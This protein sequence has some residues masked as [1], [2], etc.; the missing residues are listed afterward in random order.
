MEE[1]ESDKDDEDDDY[2]EKE[3][4][5]EDITTIHEEKKMKSYKKV[6]NLKI[7]FKVEIPLSNAIIDIEKVDNWI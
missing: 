3:E 4:K 5:V 1:V 6:S 7:D 2:N